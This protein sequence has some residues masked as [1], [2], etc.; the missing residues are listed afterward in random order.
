[1]DVAYDDTRIS[2]SNDANRNISS[3][4]GS[5]TNHRV[6]SNGN[7]FENGTP[8][9]DKH[10][11]PDRYRGTRHGLRPASPH[12]RIDRM[13]IGVSYGYVCPKDR[14]VSDPNRGCG[15]KRATRNANTIPDHDLR[16]SSKRVKDNWVLYAKAIRR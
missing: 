13:E 8:G 11:A 6:I 10:V 14:V 16:T 12:F 7:P 5:C 3:D 1:M 15:A 2:C 9:T 4:N